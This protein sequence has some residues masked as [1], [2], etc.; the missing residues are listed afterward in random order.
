MSHIRVMFIGHGPS[1]LPEDRVVNVFHFVGPGSYATDFNEAEVA[2]AEFFHS[3]VDATHSI[4]GWLSPWVSREAELRSYDLTA[5]KPRIPHIA[6]ITLDGGLTQGYAEEVAV[7]LSY[8]GEPPITPR[9]RG[10]I[11]VGPL[12][13][14]AIVPADSSTP[15]RPNASFIGDLTRAATRLADRTAVD[16]SVRSMTP[17]ENFVPIRGGYVDNA[18]DNQL[19]R[20]PDP[21]TRLL[22]TSSVGLPG[23]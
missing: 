12:A 16:W 3:T 20:G 11:Y 2:V 1:N 9:R 5:P 14:A 6:P 4:G 10:R 23:V 7:C 19:R 13:T 18:L 15:A 21:T 17:S 8:Y 22:W